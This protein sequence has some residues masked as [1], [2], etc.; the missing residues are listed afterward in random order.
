MKFKISA[1]SLKELTSLRTQVD[2]A[3]RKRQSAA[4]KDVIGKIRAL[5]SETGLDLKELF[6]ARA[7]AGKRRVKARRDG[8][9]TVKAKYAHP[10]NPSVKWSGRGRAPKWVAEYRKGGKSLDA[11]L[12]K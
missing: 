7:K 11:L 5:A 2:A 9:R 8:R 1:M 10:D 12:I 3:I 4:K 6:G